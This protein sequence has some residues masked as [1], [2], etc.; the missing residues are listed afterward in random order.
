MIDAKTFTQY[1]ADI[2]YLEQP[3]DLQQ[4]AF[5]NAKDAVPQ[6]HLAHIQGF[7]DAVGN[8]EQS[9]Q[10]IHIAGTN[11]KGTTVKLIEALLNASGHKAGSFTSPFTSTTVEKF[12]VNSVLMSPQQL[13]QLITTYITPELERLAYLGQRQ[14]S[15]FE[16]C[17]ILSLLFLRQEH[18]KYA[19]LEAGLGGLLDA[20]N[21]IAHPICT[22]ITSVGLDHT[23][24]LGKTRTDIAYN[25]AGI[26]KLHVPF[27]VHVQDSDVLEVCMQY[28]QTVGTNVTVPKPLTAA[29][30]FSKTRFVS[31]ADVGN[32]NVALNVLQAIG[33]RYKQATVQNVLENFAM[34]ARREILQT[35]PLVIMD[36]AHNHDK[37][38]NILEYIATVPCKNIY[39]I[40]GFA[41]NKAWQ[42]PLQLLAKQA[43]TVF[44]TE[45]TV[46]QRKSAK[47][48]T[49]QAAIAGTNSVAI[50]DPHACLT[51]ALEL[52]NAE[53]LILITGS[54]YLCGELRS[55]WIP[56]KLILSTANVF[57]S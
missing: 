48:T 56:E 37:I 12:S 20:T 24:I 34:I 21:I 18:C 10:I 38:T 4:Q 45:F 25:K 7:L 44:C 36:G 43:H 31:A 51:K 17:F 47:A 11:G 14:P 15:Y 28:A 22:A 33:M 49:L 26:A 52:A 46:A 53:D 35:K 8:P 16:L 29:F 6:V 57:G 19:V 3:R 30:D 55:H 13:H 9:L 41:A 23:H 2:A 27:I 5:K 54:F 50:P 32:V 40:A 39:V 42:A 1:Q